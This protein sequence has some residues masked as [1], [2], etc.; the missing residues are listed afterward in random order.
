MSRQPPETSIQP[1][2]EES[3]P[4]HRVKE[5]P[6]NSPTAHASAED[7][8]PAVE[9]EDGCFHWKVVLKKQSME[10]KFGFVM[11]NGKLEY[12]RRLSNLKVFKDNRQKE[13]LQGPEVLLVQRIHDGLL[14]QWNIE[15]PEAEVLPCDCI[16]NINGETTVKGMQQEIRS[17]K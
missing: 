3:K 9:K 12:E 14:Q 4:Q 8:E 17:Q 6:T 10:D 16:Y 2:P 15:H 11:A 13:M 5:E 7:L 1:T